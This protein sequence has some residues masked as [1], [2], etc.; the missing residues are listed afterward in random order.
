MGARSVLA[1]FVEEPRPC[2]YLGDRDASLEC[3]IMT[4]VGVD[5]LESLL[6]RGWRRQGPLYFR[7]SC[8]GCRECVSLRLPVARFRPTRGQRRAARA[9]ARFRAVI[10]RPRV[11]DE[12]LALYA[13]WHAARE[14]AKD[15]LPSPL[16]EE[17]YAVQFAYPHPAAWEMTLRDGDRIVALTLCDV[18]RKAWSAIYAFHSPDIAALS[19]GVASVTLAVDLA[20][21]RGIPH[22]YL[23]Y[24][25]LGCPSM[26]YKSGFGPH[27]LLQGLPGPDEE[28]RWV[29][30]GTVVALQDTGKEGP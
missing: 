16:D 26:R 1:H 24:R 8:A 21:E 9:C 27:E 15:W 4:G 25:V 19:P 6:V 13:A 29:E 14:R 11:D 10:E 12:R 20:R 30:A 5:E 2:S 22:V 7:P 28:P 3:R 23:G 18:T 17:S